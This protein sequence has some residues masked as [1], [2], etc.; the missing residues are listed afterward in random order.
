NYFC[1]ALNIRQFRLQMNYP[2]NGD[3]TSLHCNHDQRDHDYMFW[4]K[5]SI[6][7]NNMQLVA[8]SVKDLV[9][10]IECALDKSTFTVLRPSGHDSI[11]II[12]NVTKEDSAV[13]YCATSQDT[14]QTH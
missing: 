6:S 9:S 7:E 12:N 1:L 13:F 14:H 11:L 5:H 4:Y 2:F 8:Y 3:S 10:S